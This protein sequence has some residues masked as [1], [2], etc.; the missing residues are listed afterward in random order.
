MEAGSNL[1]KKGSGQESYLK[2]QNLLKRPLTDGFQMLVKSSAESEN[3]EVMTQNSENH[4]CC[5][6]ILNELWSL[7]EAT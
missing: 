6:I 2:G 4:E 1:E 3:N 7:F 5:I